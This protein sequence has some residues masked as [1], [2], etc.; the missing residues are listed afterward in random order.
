MVKTLDVAFVV[1]T[2]VA[3]AVVGGIATWWVTNKL[4]DGIG[5][6]GSGISTGFDK[7]GDG[8]SAGFDKLG[9]GFS[10]GFDKVGDVVNAP[11]EGGKNLG[12]GLRG[13]PTL[14]PTGAP[15]RVNP[16][17]LT[18]VQPDKRTVISMPTR[19]FEPSHVVVTKKNPQ[20]G[21]PD[22]YSYQPVGAEK[23]GRDLRNTF[24]DTSDKIRLYSDNGRNFIPGY[25][26]G[27]S[28]RNLFKKVF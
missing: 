16:P 24:I 26:L 12:Q 11:I 28:T 20:P 14:T 3:V 18:R 6:L 9:D 21:A 17:G 23:F 10:A 4:D 25:R 13:V 19:V 27:V 2:G 7:L 8:F 22:N 5:K 15:F 1:G